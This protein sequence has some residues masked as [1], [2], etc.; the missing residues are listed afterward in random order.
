MRSC[1]L[2]YMRI[3]LFVVLSNPSYHIYTSGLSVLQAYNHERSKLMSIQNDL[4][5][6]VY[7][8]MLL[9]SF[10]FLLAIAC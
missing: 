10:C 7:E 8:H 4:F 3:F 5:H 1:D 9:P 6:D 2:V